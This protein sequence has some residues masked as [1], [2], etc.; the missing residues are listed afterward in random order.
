MLG[1]G[2]RV[3]SKFISLIICVY[4]C[5]HNNLLQTRIHCFTGDGTADK[6]TESK[7]LF[8]CMSPTVHQTTNDSRTDV[9][10]NALYIA[11]QEL[12]SF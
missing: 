7:A 2:L 3:F 10:R 9:R 11:D 8:F 1:L 4:F 5:L 6:Q 12:C